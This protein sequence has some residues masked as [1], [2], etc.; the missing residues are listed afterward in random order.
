[1]N[2]DIA[3]TKKMIVPEWGEEIL[4]TGQTPLIISGEQKEQKILICGFDL[5]ETDL[6]FKKI[7]H[8]Y[9]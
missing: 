8:L 7:S 4:T 5:H 6:S 3:R 1:M 9:V 2:F